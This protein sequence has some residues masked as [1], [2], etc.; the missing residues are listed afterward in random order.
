MKIQRKHDFVWLKCVI[1]CCNI[2]AQRDEAQIFFNFNNRVWLSTF[3]WQDSASGSHGAVYLPDILKTDSDREAERS[4]KRKKISGEKVKK[5]LK[6]SLK[7]SIK[8]HFGDDDDSSQPS[9]SASSF[10][11]TFSSQRSRLLK[12]S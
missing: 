12:E 3:L 11:G 9:S 2:L 4:S 7:A 5:S 8:R 1:S 10:Y 6:M